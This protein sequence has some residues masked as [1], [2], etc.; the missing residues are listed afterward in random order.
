MRG[1]AALEPTCR[2]VIDQTQSGPCAGR[3][4]RLQ[5]DVNERVMTRI[6]YVTLGDQ[7]AA[8]DSKE[9]A[10]PTD[11]WNGGGRTH[12][13]GSPAGREADGDRTCGGGRSVTAAGSGSGR[14][15]WQQIST[16]VRRSWSRTARRVRH[17]PQRNGSLRFRLYPSG[18]AQL[19]EIGKDQALVRLERRPEFLRWCMPNRF[20]FS[21]RYRHRT[22]RCACAD[23]QR[24]PARTARHTIVTNAQ[25]TGSQP[26]SAKPNPAR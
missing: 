19:I 17:L 5:E 14:A 7:N 16:L 22:G 6:V 2:K 8:S 10:L 1:T 24:C 15:Y 20:S 21:R 12:A 9:P 3:L 25:G 23:A 26:G 18:R 4:P 11:A 13:G